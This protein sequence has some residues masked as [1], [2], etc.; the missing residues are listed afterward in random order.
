MSLVNEDLLQHHRSVRRRQFSD[1]GT[2]DGLANSERNLLSRYGAWLQALAESELEP[3]T[4]Q[5]LNFV[6]VC[7]GRAE[8]RSEFEL[9]WVK[10][11]ANRKVFYSGERGRLVELA[12]NDHLSVRQLEQIVSNAVLFNFSPEEL[13]VFNSEIAKRKS[14]ESEY[15]A[16]AT[17]HQCGGDGGAGGRCPRC[18]GNGFEP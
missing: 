4:P 13:D 3:I 6:E 9:V 11:Q 14:A 5:Q 8:P 1:F 17:C 2:W 7:R 16:L 18:G 15:A 12:L 10:Y